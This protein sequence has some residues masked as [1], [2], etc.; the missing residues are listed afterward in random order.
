MTAAARPAVLVT[1][2]GGNVGQGVLRAITSLRDEIRL[3][4]TNTVA[5]TGGNHLCDRVHLVPPAED[6]R[7]LERLR[8]I[9]DEERVGLIIPATDHETVVL[10]DAEDLP[11]VAVGAA[12]GAR[13]CFDKWETAQLF[14]ERGVPFARSMLPSS[15][16]VGPAFERWVVK[17][18][19]GRGSRDVHLDAPDPRA[20]SD[21]FVVQER[22]FG[23]EVT[24]AAYVRRSGSLHGF[25]ALERT[26]EQGT[27]VAC[28]VVTDLD[29]KLGPLV[30]GV[31][32][33]LGARGS[34]NVQVIA[35][36]DGDVVPFEV[37][38]RLSGTTSI[39]HRLGFP[40]AVWTVEEW[41]LGRT[42]SAPSVQRGCAVRLWMDV[43]YPGSTF[44]DVAAGDPPHVVF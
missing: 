8:A 21:D 17:P 37:N 11:T 16:G 27:T 41:L 28:S 31:V 9:C 24:V 38:Y 43:V 14:Q 40:D 6:A 20:F 32:E 13:A 36:D 5:V 18:R 39:R 33:A 30:L 15:S 34:C 19:T 22:A 7:Y 35:T 12:G 25:V 1:G 44:A 3:V 23:R 2:V 10:A 42:P 29:H 26:L 4:G